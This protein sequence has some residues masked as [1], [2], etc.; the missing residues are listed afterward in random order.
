[1][2]RQ[3]FIHKVLVMLAISS[4]TYEQAAEMPPKMLGRHRI[5]NIL[6][7]QFHRGRQDCLRKMN[8]ISFYEA[9]SQIML[10][11]S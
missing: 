6:C 8:A 7:R 2:R 5:A 3:D 9:G 11:I 4:G 1:M 10:E